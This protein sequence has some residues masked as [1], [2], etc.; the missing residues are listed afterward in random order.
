MMYSWGAAYGG[1]I[2]SE[3]PNRIKEM[4]TEIDELKEKFKRILGDSEQLK[5]E[6]EEQDQK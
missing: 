1:N 2:M 4:M 3:M 6:C 5:T